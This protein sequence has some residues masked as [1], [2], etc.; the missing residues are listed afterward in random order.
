MMAH[1]CRSFRVLRDSALTYSHRAQGKRT[2]VCRHG[3]ECFPRNLIAG[4]NIGRR[5]RLAEFSSC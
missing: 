1:V 3:N 2:G 4:L 5:A